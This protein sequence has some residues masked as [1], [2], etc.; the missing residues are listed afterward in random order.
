MID[1]PF[2]TN[3]RARHRTDL[4]E[5]KDRWTLALSLSWTL[6][7]ALALPPAAFAQ[8]DRY[9]VPHHRL[10]NFGFP[11]EPPRPDEPGLTPFRRPM[12]D[13]VPELN[14][15]QR[16]EDELWLVSSR[17]LESCNDDPA[18][19]VCKRNSGDEWR[20]TSLPALLASI[21]VEPQ[22]QTV[23]VVPGYRTDEFWSRRRG[24]QAYQA[25]IGNRPSVKPTRLIIWAWP[26]EE[27]PDVGPF[28]NYSMKEARTHVDG[29]WMGYFLS[30]LPEECDPFFLTYSLGTQVTVTAFADLTAA[31]AGRGFRMLAIA[32]VF[33]CDWPQA[34]GEIA[35]VSTSGHKIV[36]IRNEA[37]VALCAF[38]TW[39]RLNGYRQDRDG[40]DVLVASVPG[41]RQWDVSDVQGREHNLASYIQLPVVAR[42][43]DSLLSR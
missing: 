5:R 36:V 8:S 28:R 35:A 11:Y 4:P 33:R 30:L 26:S 29:F 25:L 7:A 19:L 38:R 37:D 20:I 13:G 1:L 15:C 16:A 41:I 21:S 6:I 2:M 39:C 31:G 27:S 34:A 12:L 22:M 23:V 10:G 14:F 3:L 42:E 18:K 40:V 9:P 43:F 32:P 24:K 17:D